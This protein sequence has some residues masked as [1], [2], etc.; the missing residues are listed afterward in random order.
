MTIDDE[1]T[2]PSLT[3][4][5]KDRRS[6]LRSAF[7]YLQW[8]VCALA[9]YFVTEAASNLAWLDI[10]GV[11][12]HLIYGTLAAAILLAIVH[13][14]PV[15]WRLSL[16]ARQSAYFALIPVLVLHLATERGARDAFARTPDGVREAALRA[17]ALKTLEEAE[18]STADAERL[19]A[20]LSETQKQV[21][22]YQK[23]IESC[24][25]AFGHRLP[26]L[27]K[28]V[29]GSLHNPEAFE[30][31]ETV[32]IVPDADRYNIAMTFRAENTFGAIRTATVKAQ[33]VADSCELQGISEAAID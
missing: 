23:Q 8:A 20:E 21:E 12:E 13:A 14:P 17:D 19:F 25:T 3:A 11:P 2:R 9:I 10:V 7:K 27:E 33:L 29:R 6:G 30:H 18:R 5:S 31:V 4:P 1:D 28:S 22:A 24:F 32:A 15:F 26:A 16:L